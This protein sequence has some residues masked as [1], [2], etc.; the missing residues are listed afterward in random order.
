MGTKRKL[1][2]TPAKRA[3]SLVLLPPQVSHAPSAPHRHRDS[4]S[5]WYVI[6]GLSHPHGT[7]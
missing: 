4:P 2:T 6:A 5:P 3:S 7:P 1:R